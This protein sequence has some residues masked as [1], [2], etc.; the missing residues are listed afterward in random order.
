MSAPLARS[1]SDRILGGV[2]A[3][4]ARSFG[5]SVGLV[6]LIAVVA[7]CFG[8]IGFWVYIAAWFLL[9]LDTTNKSGLD[10]VVTSLKNTGNS[11]TQNP[12]DLR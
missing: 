11:D 6:R 4:F 3:G 8:S 12:T 10:S 2:C 5:I 1:S 9:P 7:A